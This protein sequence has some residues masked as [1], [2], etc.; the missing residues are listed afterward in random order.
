MEELQGTLEKPL[1]ELYVP[2]RVHLKLPR[3][4]QSRWRQRVA[5]ARTDFQAWYGREVMEL[6]GSKAMAAAK[7][8]KDLEE[9]RLER[10]WMW[11]EGGRLSR[12]LEECSRMIAEASQ[13]VE[14]SSLK[15]I[16]AVPWT[17]QGI[18]KDVFT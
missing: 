15:L 14:A 3:P 17:F 1:V 11:K 4:L 10:P 2:E 6:C 16:Q 13:V 5:S 12:M 7:R 18:R 8:L 9:H